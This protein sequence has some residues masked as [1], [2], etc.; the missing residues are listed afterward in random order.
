MRQQ[1]KR[2]FEKKSEKEIEK[3]LERF[4]NTPTEEEAKREKIVN[5]LMENYNK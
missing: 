4:Y 3:A 1:R 5:K 2:G